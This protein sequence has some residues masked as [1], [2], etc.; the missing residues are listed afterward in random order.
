MHAWPSHQ[1]LWCW[2]LVA[3]LW[4]LAFVAQVDAGQE[5][6]A[7]GMANILG[8]MTS[9]YPVTGS[10]SRSAVNNQV[11]AQTQLSGMI[12]GILLFA[13]LLFL[14]P[15]F[16]FLPKV[17]TLPPPPPSMALSDAIGSSCAS[18]RTVCARCDRHRL[19]H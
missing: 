19:R 10:F 7:L 16:E 6:I 14:T 9:A 8:S 15:V 18:R 4:C 2:A 11:G 3:H 13:T 5:L 17:R 12:T 1:G